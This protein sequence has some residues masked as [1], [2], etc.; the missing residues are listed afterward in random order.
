MMSGATFR[1]S[2]KDAAGASRSGVISA[3]SEAEAAEALSRAGLTP[4]AL[5]PGGAPRRAR[6]KLDDRAAAMRRLASLLEAKAPLDRALKLAG[7]SESAK[8]LF[9]DLSLSVAA[10]RPLSAAMADWPGDFSEAEAA[11]FTAGEATGALDRSADAAATLLERRSSGRRAVSS[12]LAYPAF[13][14]VAA[15]LALAVFIGFA[16][17]RFEEVLRATGAEVSPSTDRFFWVSGILREWGGPL[18][19]A[20]FAGLAGAFL[21][22]FSPGGKRMITDL[23]LRLPLIGPLL[24]DRAFETFAGAL[25]AMLTGGATLPEAARLSSRLLG[26]PRLEEA[27]RAAAAGVDRGEDYSAALRNTGHFPETLIAFVEIGEETGALAPLL[28]RAS[29]HFGQE[30][31]A[32]AKRLSAVAAPAATAVLGLLIGIGAYLMMTAVLDVYDAAL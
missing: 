15:I 16:Q 28:T 19:L 3:P 8:N 17:P 4:L 32:R 20:V 29:A 10:G 6:A 27:G 2:A 14:V 13:V 23:S 30:A 26:S 1:Y 24:A 12:A 22:S 11:L 9:A 7:G 5:K 18:L 25:G 21:M 31:E